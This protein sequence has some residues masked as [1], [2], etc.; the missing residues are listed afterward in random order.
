MSLSSGYKWN[1]DNCLDGFWFKIEECEFLLKPL[2]PFNA[3]MYESIAKENKALD[4]LYDFFG[5]KIDK[6]KRAKHIKNN[7]SNFINM[8]LLDWKNV[9]D[10]QGKEIKFSKENANKL[11]NEFPLA[12]SVLFLAANNKGKE[13]SEAEKKS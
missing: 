1:I 9:N 2:S 8:F 6:S 10:E 11:F 12:A 5:P 4:N 13:E 7:V 3:E